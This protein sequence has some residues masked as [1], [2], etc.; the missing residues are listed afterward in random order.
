MTGSP[1][2]N[3]L[4]VKATELTSGH[5]P[6]P[7]TIGHLIRYWAERTPDAVAIAA[8]GRPSLTY[9]R[10]WMQVR[11]AM[12]GLGAMGI[13]QNDRVAI[14][15][16]NGPEMAVAF[17]SVSSCCTGA[18]LNPAYGVDEFVFYLSDL[19]VR[20]VMVLS[21]TASPAI[22][23][24]RRLNIRVLE[25]STAR[26]GE[27]GT[28]DIGVPA[29]F[30]V[31]VNELAHPDDTALVLHTSGTT[32]RPKI[33]PL[34]HTNLR[35]S[36]H[37]TSRALGLGQDDRCLC[38]MPLFHVHGLIGS[39]FSSIASGGAVICP[40]GFQAPRFFEWME[41]CRPTWYTAAPTM[42][43]S[44]L[45]RASSHRVG[46]TRGSLRFVRS[47]S[48]PLPPRLMEEL[49]SFFGAPVVEAYSMTEASHQI[50]LNPI[51]PGERK[52]GS[53]GLPAGPQVVVVDQDGNILPAGQ[54]GEI[55]IRGDS[56]IGGYE[57]NP[58]ANRTAFVH[59]WFR[60]GDQGYLDSDGY[61]FITGRLKE[62]INR[63]GEKISPREIDE[64]LMDHPAV[65]QAVAFPCQHPA[66]GE[67][68]AAAV[69]LR[70]AASATER[71][72]R[73]FAAARLADFKVPRRIAIVD[74][75]PKGPTGKLQRI[76]LAK[77]LGIAVDDVGRNPEEIP[78]VA[79]ATPLERRLASI[80]T[81]VLGIQQVGIHDSFL[82]LGGD[83]VLATLVIARVR[84]ALQVE[85][86]FLDFFEASTIAGLA[87]VV[88]RNCTGD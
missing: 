48:A 18:P 56:V 3:T 42:H 2:G 69:V 84:E 67:E 17:L 21:G 70:E 41:E 28:F 16:P 22:G 40:P 20:A 1:G 7:M 34:S 45:S 62:I 33:V 79:P 26:E 75:I 38:I 60:T 10:L 12:Q 52:R 86:S 82:G 43:Q 23:A 19:R 72:I 54:I 65:A 57:N 61:L 80:W 77:K 30:A 74:E 88:N 29:G 37:N 15:M 50:A 49:E 81:E 6:I 85:V 78:F 35:V 76:D 13:G 68:V 25:L 55:A 39:L 47:S 31:G 36:A 32:S 73:E 9:A 64:V 58:E 71:E 83:S 53:V 46:I 66:L 44:I 24:A 8:P 14:V 87:A 27:A 11:A 5:L 4:F 51:P 59:G 63:G